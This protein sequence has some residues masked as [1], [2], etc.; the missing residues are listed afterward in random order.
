MFSLTAKVVNSYGIQSVILPKEFRLSVAEVFIRR[1]GDDIVLSP[2]MLSWE[3][4]FANSRLAPEEFMTDI[5]DDP[6]Q[7]R[8]F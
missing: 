1:Q 6:P 3:D 5:I 8:I 4:Y 7:E 2:Q